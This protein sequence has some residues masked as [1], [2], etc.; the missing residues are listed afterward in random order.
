MLTFIVSISVVLK[1]VSSDFVYTDFHE[2]HGLVFNGDAGTTACAYDPLV[3][4][5]FLFFYSVFEYDF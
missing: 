4:D 1:T 3:R 5:I 2:T